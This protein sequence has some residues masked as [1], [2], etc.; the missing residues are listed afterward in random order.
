MCVSD[1]AE[2]RR[3]LKAGA[4]AA[5]PPEARD[6]FINH[7]KNCPVCKKYEPPVQSELFD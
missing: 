5:A 2:G 7:V 4:E 6:T 1:C 3:L